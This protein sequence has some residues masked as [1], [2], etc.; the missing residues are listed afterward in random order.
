MSPEGQ[1]VRDVP[2]KFYVYWN[3]ELPSMDKLLEAAEVVLKLAALFGNRAKICCLVSEGSMTENTSRCC[4]S[5]SRSARAI[6]RLSE[7]MASSKLE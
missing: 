5:T 3:K 1:D 6:S 2:L 4:A 7:N